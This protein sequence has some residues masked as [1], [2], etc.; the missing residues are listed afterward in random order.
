[1]KHDFDEV[2]D[3]K[4]T[5]STQ[6]DYI[7]DRFG[8]HD[9]LPFSISDTDF[10]MPIEIQTALAQFNQLGIY[11]YTRWNHADFKHSIVDHMQ[12]RT[13]VAADAEWV[14][15]SP[16][17]MYTISL[18]IRE[19]CGEHNR[20]LTFTP[21]YDSFYRVVQNNGC[22]LIESQLLI[23]KGHYEIDFADLAAKLTSVDVFLLCSP[24]NPTG[25]LW[26]QGELQKIVD[27]CQANGVKIISDEIHADINLSER[28]HVPILKFYAQYQNLFLV[29]SASKMFN[30]PGLIG[31]YALIP[32]TDVRLRLNE[33]MHDRDFVSS[34]STLG[35]LATMV[36]YNQCD[37]YIEELS[38][39]IKQN[40]AVVE[41][42]IAEK[43]PEF[44]YQKSEATYLAW[45]DC[46][47]MPWTMAELQKALVK[48]GKVGIMNG[49]I[50]GDANYLRM[51]CGAPLS[52]IE[53][54]LS[55]IE[56]AVE[57]LRAQN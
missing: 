36:G 9:L 39:Y 42:F 49:A 43:L 35:M 20:V 21:M 2:V 25:R 12:R 17:V 44:A 31:S 33:I 50:Y 26:T 10:R 29:S 57:S 41:K 53:A 32:D 3:R 27:L 23:K 16:S 55:R 6:W 11:G 18:L 5:Y 30:T 51:N 19:L 28:A 46:T 24:H 22:A 14:I 34:A 4:G 13:G 40:L 15:Y 45:I 37:Y 47:Q 56:L 1:M 8:E 52:K 54:G 38:A 48:V 7:Q